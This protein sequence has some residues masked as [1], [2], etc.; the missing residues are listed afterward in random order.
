MTGTPL[1]GA[2]SSVPPIEAIARRTIS[3]PRARRRL[4]VAAADLA[5]QRDLDDRTL[6]SGVL[7]QLA[8]P[9]ELPADR[10][11]VLAG[12]VAHQ[13][14]QELVVAAQ[15]HLLLQRRVAL[16]QRRRRLGCARALCSSARRACV[17]V[18]TR[19]ATMATKSQHGGRDG[20]AM[21][22]DEAAGPVGRRSAR[23]LTGSPASQ[24]RRSSLNAST[25]E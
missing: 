9:V 3:G 25:V 7:D 16:A 11:R 12:G 22:G 10:A 4:G 14:L 8:G 19:P 23:A 17:T 2:A 21:S 1:V 5:Q 13:Q 18:P 20:A 24:R 15:E 6:E